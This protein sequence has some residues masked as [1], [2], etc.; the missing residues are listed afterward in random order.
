LDGLHELPNN[1]TDMDKEEIKP[2]FT[3]EDLDACWSHRY[4]KQYLIDILNG[5]Y[6]V[7][8]A[9]EDLRSLIGSR[10]DNRV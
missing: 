1:K 10:F 5:D 7:E 4:H 2:L 9:R 8:E 6:K 3:E